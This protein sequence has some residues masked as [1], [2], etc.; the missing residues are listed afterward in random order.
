MSLTRANAEVVLISRAGNLMTAAGLDG[1]TV[2]GTN[3]DL[4]D[5]IG[6][7]IRKVGGTV[8]DV[9]NVADSDL[10]SISSDDYDEFFDYSEYRLLQNIAGNLDDVDIRVGPQEQK[11]SQLADFLDRRIERLKSKLEAEY[12][13]GY[14]TITAGYIDLNFQEEF[15]TA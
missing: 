15:E 14:A 13:L 11:L 7:G 1:V 10:T 5:P 6:Y 2:D 12:G 8:A 3:S 9:T 4:N